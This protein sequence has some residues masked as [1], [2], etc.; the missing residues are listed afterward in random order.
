MSAQVAATKV[1]EAI[2]NLKSRNVKERQ[3]VDVLELSH[4]LTDA[5]EHF[6]TALDTSI[7]DEFRDIAGYIQRARD[8]IGGLRPHDI[9]NNRLPRAGE[10]LEAIVHDTEV[11]TEKI[12]S[13]AEDVL[14]L[15]PDTTDDFAMQVQDRMLVIIE[16]CSFQDLTGQRVSKVVSTLKQIEDRITR[17]AEA[18]GLEEEGIADLTPEEIRRRELLL[19]GPAIGGPETAQADIDKMFDEGSASN[20]DDIDAMFA[21]ESSDEANQDDIDAMFS[22]GDDEEEVSQDDIDAM[23]R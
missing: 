20:Q 19:N 1:K 23:F 17:F 13:T 21:S 9:Q 18:M 10:E 8:E 7:K 12:M 6:F 14:A 11:A 4:T 15:D 3:L 2:T 5:M 16:A 22:E